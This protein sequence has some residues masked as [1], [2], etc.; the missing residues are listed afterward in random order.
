M[1]AFHQFSRSDAHN[2]FNLARSEIIHKAGIGRYDLAVFI[3]DGNILRDG[4]KHYAQG[5][6][7][8]QQ[9]SV[10]EDFILIGALSAGIGGCLRG[11]CHFLL[12]SVIDQ[13][14][15]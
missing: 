13:S 8:T 6:I 14:L 12:S 9:R 11:G 7:F 1:L 10:R 4:I 5:F 3:Q 15:Y 2:F